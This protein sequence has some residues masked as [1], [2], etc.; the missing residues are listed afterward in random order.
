MRKQI[1]WHRHLLALVLRS[2]SRLHQAADVGD[3]RQFLARKQ[4]RELGEFSMKRE[5]CVGDAVD[6]RRQRRSGQR[7]ASANGSIGLE[8]CIVHRDDGV[9]RVV[10]AEKKHT[11]RYTDD[12]AKLEIELRPGVPPRITRFQEEAFLQKRDIRR[13]VAAT[14]AQLLGEDFNSVSSKIA[15]PLSDVGVSAPAK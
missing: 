13:Q 5:R 8:I 2:G 9:I 10:A 12:L 4:A 1:Q 3:N 15:R 7:E 11:E 6:G 14:I